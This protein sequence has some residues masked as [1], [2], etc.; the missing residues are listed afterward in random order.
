MFYMTMEIILNVASVLIV[1]LPSL[2]TIF[3]G[4]GIKIGLPLTR[5]LYVVTLVMK[6]VTPLI[7]VMITLVF[8]KR[9]YHL[10]LLTKPFHVEMFDPCFSDVHCPV[11]FTF[12]IDVHASPD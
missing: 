1:P 9:V 4:A 3:G 6:V 7:T 8:M 10:F 5:V 11:E 12:P 2:M